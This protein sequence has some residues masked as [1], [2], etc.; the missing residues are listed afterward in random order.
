M[1]DAVSTLAT[2]PTFISRK[3]GYIKTTVLRFK[4]KIAMPEI[5]EHFLGLTNNRI[6]YA[7]RPGKIYQGL[8]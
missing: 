4:K 8:P 1:R 3:W 7:L 5:R 6:H 2:E